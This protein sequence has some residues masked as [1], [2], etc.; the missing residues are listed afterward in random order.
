MGGGGR[1]KFYFFVPYTELF[2]ESHHKD[3]QG[4]FSQFVEKVKDG[5]SLELKK[6]G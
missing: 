1:V 3:L 5:L 4:I 6:A 2:K